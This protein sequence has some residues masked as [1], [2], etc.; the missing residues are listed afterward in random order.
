MKRATPRQWMIFFF[1]ALAWGSSYMWIKIALQELSPGRIACIRVCIASALLMILFRLTKKRIPLRGATLARFFVLATLS[2]TIPFN[3][4]IWGAS[5]ISSMLTGVLNG[6]VPLFTVILA[7]FFLP[8]E[9]MNTVK[10]LGLTLGMIGSV[11]LVASGNADGLAGFTHMSTTS[12]LTGA[13]AVLAASLSYGMSA[14]FA[15]RKLQGIDSITL[16]T[17]VTTMAAVTLTFIEVAF[18]RHTVPV[19]PQL[20]LTW[21]ALGWMGMVSSCVAFILYFHLLAAW[22]ASRVSFVMYVTPL[23]GMVLGLVFLDERPG[24]LLY[25]GAAL[26][27]SGIGITNIRQRT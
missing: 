1:L 23:V 24:I 27:F 22:D 25:S 12:S 2:I 6:T 3:L 9:Q 17:M 13:V 21:L 19:F 14:V 10:L 4:L 7:H 26:V 8:G 15:R 16:A 20:P 18:H 5:Q 11:L